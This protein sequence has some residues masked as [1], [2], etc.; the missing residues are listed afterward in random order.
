MNL[1]QSGYCDADDYHSSQHICA[2]RFKNLQYFT[3][4]GSNRY[5]GDAY[6]RISLTQNET[7]KGKVPVFSF[8]DQGILVQVPTFYTPPEYHVGGLIK[9]KSIMASDWVAN[10][11]NLKERILQLPCLA[12]LLL[13]N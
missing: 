13:A 7:N 4:E 6:H 9:T 12:M 10:Q 11:T 1:D 8:I 3:S 2:V 5:N